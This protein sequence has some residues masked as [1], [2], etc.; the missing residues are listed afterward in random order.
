MKK[1]IYTIL[2]SIAAIIFF[3]CGSDD[4]EGINYLDNSIVEGKWC[5]IQYVDSHVMEFKNN[6]ATE[7][8]YDKYTHR[9]KQSFNNGYYKISE[10]RMFFNNSNEGILYKVNKDSLFLKYANYN[11]YAKYIKIKEGI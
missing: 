7:K 1:L 5:W 9:E 6:V 10:D 8:I 2:I 11:E 3:A 4:D